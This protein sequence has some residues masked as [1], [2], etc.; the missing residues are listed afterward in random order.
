MRRLIIFLLTFMCSHSIINAGGGVVTADPALEFA[1]A[2][3][4]ALLQKEYSKRDKA[5]KAIAT[6]E[7]GVTTAMELVHE[8]EKK[9]LNYLGN[10]SH[11]I[12]NA[13]QIKHI[14]ELFISIGDNCIKL[15]NTI[16]G[17]LKGTVVTL[18][19][20]RTVEKLYEEIASLTNYVT[21]LCTSKFDLKDSKDDNH[22]NL[23][24]AQERYA[25]LV[26]IETRLKT[27]NDHIWITR[28]YVQC[29][30]W[31]DL[32]RGLDYDGYIKFVTAKVNVDYIISNWKSLTNK[33]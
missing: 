19:V 21:T 32:W 33:K 6:A 24:S 26:N 16:P 17:H 8:V 5:M 3:Q 20:D 2:G 11:V 18:L 25:I 12:G 9:L 29:W 22:V 30:G 27:I 31:K 13:Y 15:K 10:A 23:L 28:Y 7:V 14:A 4:C 1:I